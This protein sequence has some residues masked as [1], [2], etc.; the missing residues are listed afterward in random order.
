MVRQ[1]LTVQ[2][3]HWQVMM[4]G[5]FLRYMNCKVLLT[6]H[7]MILRFKEVFTMLLSDLTALLSPF[8]QP[9]A[10]RH[11][12]PIVTRAGNPAELEVQ[13]PRISELGFATMLHPGLVLFWA[14]DED[15]KKHRSSHL[16]SIKP[17]Q[18]DGVLLEG[19][20]TSH[21]TWG[22]PYP[23]PETLLAQYTQTDPVFTTQDPL[24]N[25]IESTK[26]PEME[27]EAPIDIARR[28]F[29][30]YAMSLGDE[31]SLDTALEKG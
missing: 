1:L 7:V 19:Q 23:R 25:D 16:F 17:T 27:L 5:V 28:Y 26:Q 22:P 15:A 12:I 13:E 20:W 30:R 18:Q 8:P 9:H 2:S 14:Y 11:R 31:D 29:R 4:I 3:S 21:S 24:Q 6:L 10:I